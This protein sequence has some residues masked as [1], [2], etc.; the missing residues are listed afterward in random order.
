MTASQKALAALD[1]DVRAGRGAPLEGTRRAT[2]VFIIAT[3]R[4]LTGK[5]FLA[6]L[7]TDFL[8][9]DGGRVKAFDLNPSE[10]ALVEFLPAV[11]VKADLG[12]TRAQMSLFDRLI[13]DD[14]IAKVIDLGH[15]SFERF[16]ALSDEIG[17]LP[18][19]RRRAI[20]TIIL[21]PADPHP[22]AVRAYAVLMA[23]LP[24]TIVVPVFNEAITK[25]QKFRDQ[26]P[27]ARAAAV[28]LHIPLLQPG[29][30]AQV[31]KTRHSFVEFHTQLP[32]AIP[33]G[34]ALELRAWTRRVFLEFREFEL[35]L[36]L[37]KLRTSLK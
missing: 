24:T 11:T 36:L 37:E 5:T 12:S 18:E 32:V 28:P 16:F 21:F 1:E 4:P 22:A 29:L 33:I 14:G 26:Y 15:G 6:R 35:R 27:I 10:G 8:R 17:F 20:E 3:P 7:F 19:A 31:A 13:I 23:R 30:Q 9:L 34:H 25:G 2:P